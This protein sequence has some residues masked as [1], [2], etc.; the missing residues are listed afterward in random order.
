MEYTD[1]RFKVEGLESDQRLKFLIPI[2]R[3][4]RWFEF[5]KKDESKEILIKVLNNY[6]GELDFEK[7]YFIPTNENF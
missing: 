7:D 5:W 1:I 2:K 4:K 3:K 6:K